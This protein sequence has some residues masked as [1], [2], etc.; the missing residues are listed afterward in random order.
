MRRVTSLDRAVAD[1]LRRRRVALGLS[2]R[3]IKAVAGIEPR[4]LARYESGSSPIP[5]GRLSMIC[6]ALSIAPD[7][8][9][10]RASTNGACGL[11]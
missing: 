7:E 8:L 3:S 5:K 4:D 2:P 1:I 10:V 11:L 9:L 6:Q